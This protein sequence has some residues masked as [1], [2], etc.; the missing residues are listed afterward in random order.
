[1]AK[2]DVETP[3]SHGVGERIKVGGKSEKTWG[4]FEAGCEGVEE[5]KLAP[6]M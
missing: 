2:E 5:P 1:M 6:V 3:P 4:V